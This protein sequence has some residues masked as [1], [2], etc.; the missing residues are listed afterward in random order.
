MSVSLQLR[1][2]SCWQLPRTASITASAGC[3]TELLTPSPSDR[4]EGAAGR[5]AAKPASASVVRC[6]HCASAFARASQKTA[7]PSAVEAADSAGPAA[8]LQ[9]DKSR[10]TSPPP[11]LLSLSLPRSSAK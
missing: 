1:S 10:C 11:V 7:R 5:I 3:N 8:T 6:T 4:A 9:K 2:L